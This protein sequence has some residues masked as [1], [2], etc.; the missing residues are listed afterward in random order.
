MT[1]IKAMTDHVGE[2]RASMAALSREV[3]AMRTA[4]E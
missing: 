3:D 1:A 2:F 4:S